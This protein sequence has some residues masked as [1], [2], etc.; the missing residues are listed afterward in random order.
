MRAFLAALLFLGAASAQSPDDRTAIEKVIRS[1]RTTEPVATLFT[2]DA[3]SD[4]PRLRA[5]E[6]AMSKAGHEPWSE[7]G[8][9]AL[10][11][12]SVQMLSADAAIVN[13]TETQ[14]G[15][16]ATG[17]I[18]VVIALRKEKG[19][20]KIAYLRLT[21]PVPGPVIPRDVPVLPPQ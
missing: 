2:A 15:V 10:L 1:L 5:I 21:S 19:E 17:R 11:I 14:M 9:P 6:Q 4:Y 7:V 16:F 13:A 20:W 3:D 8:P 18:P 12:N